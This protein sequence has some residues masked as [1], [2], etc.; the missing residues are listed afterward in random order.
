GLIR[1][2]ASRSA[3]PLA[4]SGSGS[5]AVIAFRVTD[6]APPGPAAINLLQNVGSTW[7]VPGGTDAQGNDFLFDLEPRPRN[8]PGDPLDGQIEVRSAANVPVSAASEEEDAAKLT[9]SV[10]LQPDTTAF[11][12]A[13]DANVDPVGRISNPSSAAV[14]AS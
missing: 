1:I 14:A 11:E 9:P 4:F 6:N 10:P 8:T 12:V 13:R 2:S 3:G 7:S 5:L